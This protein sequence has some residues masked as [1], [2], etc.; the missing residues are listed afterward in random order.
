MKRSIEENDRETED[1]NCISKLTLA[2]SDLVLYTPAMVNV[3]GVE[4]E[5]AEIVATANIRK[6]HI[7]WDGYAMLVMILI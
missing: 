7:F 6:K 1:H 4:A 5:A 3:W 2:T